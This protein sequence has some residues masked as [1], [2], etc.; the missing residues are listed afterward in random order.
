MSKNVM[1]LRKSRADIDAENRGELETLARHKKALLELAKKMKLPID[2]IYE[3]VASGETIASRPVMQQL[4]HDIEDGMWD[5]VLVMEVE[6]LAR[7]DGIDQ[8]IVLNTFKLGNTKII[9][10]IKTYDPNDE[11]DEEYFEFGLF[12]SRR[13][14]KTINR[15]IQ[16]GRIASVKEGKF[17]TSVPP[18]GYDKVKLQND[19]GYTLQPNEL[20]SKVVKMIFDLY[21]QGKGMTV[22]SNELDKLNIKPR[23][24]S[25][26]SKSTISDILHNPVYIGK[27]RW[28]YRAEKKTNVD[29]EIKKTRKLNEKYLYID[30]IHEPIVNEEVFN[31]AQ[32]VRKQNT[33]KRVKDDLTLKNPLTGLIYCKK[34]GSVMNRLGSNKKNPYDTIR[35]SNKYCDNISA[36]MFL[37][38][39]KLVKFLSDWLKDYEIEISRNFGEESKLVTISIAEEKLQSLKKD[40]NIIED[41]ISET[42]DLLERKVY[43]VEI[44]QKRL[45]QLTDKKNQLAQSIAD[46]ETQKLNQATVNDIKTK[47][48]PQFKKL[49]ELYP[50]IKSAEEKNQ[51]LKNMVSRI[52]YIKTEPNHKGTLSNDNFTLDL[53]PLL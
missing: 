44:F 26:W 3:E 12:M 41:Q 49:I 19:K 37:I 36:P 5:S 46:L 21:I 15:R 20:E 53:Y 50:K 52:E 51:I 30:G 22:I 48:I 23:Y 40:V 8:Q 45:Q 13:E 31:Q 39:Q 24:R 4:L 34:C 14:Y 29:G 17:I 10:P 27:I 33:Y 38:E 35:C 32:K 9:T 28:S 25:T 16:R 2:K 42:Y 47:Y 43:T 1:Y 11:Y 6:R 7:G 18:Y